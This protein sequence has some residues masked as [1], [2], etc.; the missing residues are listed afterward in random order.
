MWLSIIV[1]V[2]T[3]DMAKALIAM[4]IK[5]LLNSKTDG[6]TKDVA[7]AMLD[8]VAQSRANNV[9]VDAFDAIKQSL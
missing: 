6:V 2:V 8:G 4:L 7:E 3:S 5:K 9:A 1:K